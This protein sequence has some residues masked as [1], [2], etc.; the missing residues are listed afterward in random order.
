M[1]ASAEGRIVQGLTE[2]IRDIVREEIA[3]LPP[4]SILG[5][6]DETACAQLASE[7][8]ANSLSR[9]GDFFGKLEND[10][11]VDSLTMAKHLNL[12]T[13]RNISS[14]ITTPLK[15]VAKRLG[16][17]MPWIEELNIDGR[18]VWRDRDGIAARMCEAVKA[19]QHRRAHEPA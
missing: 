9:A 15:R 6:Y 17:G 13:P 16:L 7:L 12:G 3:K 1:T 19:E 11:E 5:D 2:L 14:A 8:G 18:T 4:A 10:G